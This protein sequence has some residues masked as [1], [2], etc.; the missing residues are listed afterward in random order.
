MVKNSLPG[1]EILSGGECDGIRPLQQYIENS[2]ALTRDG[3][4]T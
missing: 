3:A 1:V 2:A 4:D